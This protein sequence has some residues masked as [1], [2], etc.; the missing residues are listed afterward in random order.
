MN[1]KMLMLVNWDVHKA[2]SKSFQ[3]LQSPNILEKNKAYWFFQ[4]WPEKNVQVDVIDCSKLSVIHRIEKDLLRFYVVQ[5]LKASTKLRRYDLLISHGAQS[6]IFL[7]FIRSI[8]NLKNPPHIII[9]VGCL[10]GGRSNQPEL[11]I[12]QFAMRSVSGLI[13][14]ATSQKS[15]YDKFFPFL[16]K[17]VFFVPFGVDTEFFKPLNVKQEDYILSI[18]YKFRDW[19]TLIN[20]YS[21]IKTNTA[22]KIVGPEDLNIELPNNVNLQLY[23]P[24]NILKELIAKAKF[25]VLPLVD[26]PYAHGQMTLLQSMAMGK[27]VIVTKMPSTVD[28]I[29]D[30]EDAFFVRL[31]DVEDMR[32]KIE[33]LLNNPD[34]VARLGK[35]ARKTV[36][37]KFNEKHMAEGLYEACKALNII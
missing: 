8:F 3:E 31:N 32:N 30:K 29:N 21:Q 7:A 17:K 35:N 26:L 24:I 25:I 34:E 16:S 15:H 14:H 4:Y 2:D 1:K 20:A 27:A 36:E 12:F 37:S 22:L 28:Y 9:D 10:N 33:F 6:A 19:L 11:S 5:A 18:G 13:Y 23:V